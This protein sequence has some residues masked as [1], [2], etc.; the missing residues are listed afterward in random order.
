MEEVI[1]DLNKS[2]TDEWLA[3]Y[4]YWLTAQGIRGMDAGTLKQV[5]LQ[6][7]ADK[8]MHSEILANTIIQ[9]VGTTVM[10]FDQWEK[11]GSS[12]V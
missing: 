6:R 2:L 11:L 12:L 3:H 8:L 1:S 10:K 4:Q 7:P 5:Q 9:L